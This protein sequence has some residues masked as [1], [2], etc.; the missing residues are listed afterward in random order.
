M[1]YRAGNKSKLEFAFPSQRQHPRDHFRLSLAP[2][3]AVLGFDNHGYE[4]WIYEP[5]AG[6]TRIDVSKGQ[7]PVGS[8]ICSSATDTL[9]LTKT[10]D[11]FRSLG[12]YP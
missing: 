10:Q 12:I 11:R 6:P 5:L 2:R 7:A 1:Q 3:G 8:I 4:Y 9:T